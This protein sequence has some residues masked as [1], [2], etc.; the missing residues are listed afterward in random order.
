MCHRHCCGRGCWSPPRSCRD[1]S[2]RGTPASSL[3]SDDCPGS[4]TP[5]TARQTDRGRRRCRSRGIRRSRST[6]RPRRQRAVK[7]VD[8]GF[9]MFL[10]HASCCDRRYPYTNSGSYECRFIV[11]RNHVLVNSNVCFTQHLLGF[12]AAYVFIAEVY[13]H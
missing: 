7:K 4:S 5:G 2:R 6:R 10:F 1:D 11:I 8:H 13:Q 12:F 9:H 3:P